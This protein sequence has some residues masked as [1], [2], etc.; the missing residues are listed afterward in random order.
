MTEHNLDG[1]LYKDTFKT[2]QSSHL[3]PDEQQCLHCLE[4]VCTIICPAKVYN[5]NES[6]KK[7]TVS[8]ENAL[9]AVR[10]G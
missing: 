10:A 3:S 8:Y 5:Y 6:E 2:S 1:K 9:S 7:L 4:K